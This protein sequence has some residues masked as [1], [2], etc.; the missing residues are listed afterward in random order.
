MKS[1]SSGRSPT[2]V[3]SSERFACVFFLG[4]ALRTFVVAFLAGALVVG[5]F[6]VAMHVVYTACAYEEHY[7]Q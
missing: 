4:A 2:C 1:V 3:R 5:F 6:F 7:L